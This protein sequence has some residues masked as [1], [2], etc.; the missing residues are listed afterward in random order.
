MS[1]PSDL[2][3]DQWALVKPLISP[4]PSQPGTKCGNLRP[5]VNALFYMAREGCSWRGLPNDFP[6]WSMVRHHFNK[7]NDAGV[8]QNVLDTVNRAVREK[9]GPKKRPA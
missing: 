8:F 2:T 3:D 9:R 1:Y 7:W 4:P 5:V 6:H